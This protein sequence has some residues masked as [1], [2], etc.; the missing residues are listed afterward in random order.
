[1]VALEDLVWI[2]KTG[3]HLAS[4][5]DGDKTKPPPEKWVHF[6][7]SIL[8]VRLCHVL[9]K[10]GLAERPTTTYSIGRRKK[11]IK[12]KKTPKSFSFPRLLFYGIVRIKRMPAWTSFAII[13]SPGGME[14]RDG[15]RT[16][17]ADRWRVSCFTYTLGSLFT[18]IS[19][20]ALV[21]LIG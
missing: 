1:M 9:P 15:I 12:R 21:S 18:R 7:N 8:G 4:E 20:F 13:L 10:I 5:M 16:C 6:F 11:R 19:E 17:I 14:S 2:P 3:S